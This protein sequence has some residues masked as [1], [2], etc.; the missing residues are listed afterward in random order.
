ML[1]T[2]LYAQALWVLIVTGVVIRVSQKLFKTLST[3]V[4]IGLPVGLLLSLLPIVNGMSLASTLYGV[5]DI[6]STLLV[7]I[8][9]LGIFYRN[10]IGL[11][12][13]WHVG[14]VFSL[15]LVGSYLF[16][17]PRWFELGYLPVSLTLVGVLFILAYLSNSL[18]AMCAVTL[19]SAALA[20]NVMDTRNSFLYIGDSLF[21]LI[22]L[23]WWP[24]YLFQ[25][26]RSKRQASTHALFRR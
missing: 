21:A 13:L 26:W 14:G 8:L 20:F 18:V 3:G 2:V 17:E 10:D 23:L 22:Y 25:L 1:L 9:T 4:S 19:C 15:M 7:A 16:I 6:P 5:F 11:T 12:M 24:G